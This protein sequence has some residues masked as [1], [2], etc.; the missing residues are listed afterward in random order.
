MNGGS[1]CT[2]VL[3][4]EKE[5]LSGMVILILAIMVWKAGGSYTNVPVQ[6]AGQE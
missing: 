5:R 6:T 2:N 1:L 3:T 4:V